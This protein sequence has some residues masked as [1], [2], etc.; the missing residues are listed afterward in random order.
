MRKKDTYQ[1]TVGSRVY[2][3]DPCYEP[4]TWCQS[5]ETVKPGRWNCQVLYTKDDTYV[6]KLIVRHENHART[7]MSLSPEIYDL[8]VDSGQFGVCDAEYYETSNADE[9]S[10]RDFYAEVCSLTLSDSLPSS[11]TIADKG[12]FCSSGYGDGCYA[13]RI[14]KSREQI[15]GFEIEFIYER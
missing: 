10:A 14:A 5:V 4:G 12:V 13:A 11:G 6:R 9:K 7:K 2:L 8:G 15:V 3:T 1:I